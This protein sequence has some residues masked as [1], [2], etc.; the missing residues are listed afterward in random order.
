MINTKNLKNKNVLLDQ[1]GVIADFTGAALKALNK[2]Y[3]KKVTIKQYAT[4]FGK[5]GINDYYGITMDKMW[6]AV[7]ET[8]NFW[9]D[10]EPIPW[11]Q[12]L[13]DALAEIGQVT[14]ITQPGLDP[15]CA[16]QKLQWLDLYFG[17]KSDAVFMGGR[18]YLMAGNGILIDDYVKNVEAFR[19]A[20]GTAVLVP[21]TWNDPDCSFDKVWKAIIS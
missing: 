12:K 18:K 19:S 9:L 17:I 11:Y 20:G 3:N 14:I 21:S 5:W 8:P 2:I 7:D 13:Y 1:D 16:K 10:I 15:E 6:E 4:E